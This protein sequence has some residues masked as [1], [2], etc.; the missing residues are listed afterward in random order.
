MME[1]D[2][3]ELEIVQGSEVVIVHGSN[4][5]LRGV[6]GIAD[7]ETCLTENEADTSHGSVPYE[8]IENGGWDPDE[9]IPDSVRYAGIETPPSFWECGD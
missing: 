6:L 7:L 2:V 9:P 8:P 5:V 1:N 3:V 4:V